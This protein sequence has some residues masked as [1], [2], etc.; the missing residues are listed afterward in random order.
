MA[1]S[2]DHPELGRFTWDVDGWRKKIDAPGFD[3]FSYDF[4]DEEEGGP[5]GTYDLHFFTNHEHVLPSEAQIA[6]ARKVLS[7]PAGIVKKAA[8]A[9]WAD[10]N[11]EGPG[12]GMWWQD[13]LEQMAEL[14]DEEE[15]PPPE[16]PEDVQGML[17]LTSMTVRLP[18][19]RC[20]RPVV[21]L[22]LAAAFE[23]EHG[24]GVLTDGEK[25]LGIGYQIDVAPFGA[26]SRDRAEEE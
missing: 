11:G 20:D 7:D 23:E 25:V 2:W 9:L 17:Q 16:G 15:L 18:D 3:G 10:F 21:E 4:G 5:N 24:L 1:A 12:S 13:G 14:L 19:Y 22:A 8:A 26:V 6:V